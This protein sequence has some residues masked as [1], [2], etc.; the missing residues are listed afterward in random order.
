M[1]Y[2]YIEGFSLLNK[3]EKLKIVAEFTSNPEKAKEI[4]KSFWIKNNKE[5]KIFDEF[6][7]NTIS[8]YGLPYGISPNYMINGKSY[9]LPMVTEE[10]SV[11]AAAAK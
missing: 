2:K 3:E 9:L 7:E 8:L 1:K 10:S 5:S 11:V 4:Y 6:S